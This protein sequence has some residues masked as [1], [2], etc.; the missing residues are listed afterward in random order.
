MHLYSDLSNRNITVAIC[1]R[2]M[3]SSPISIAPLQEKILPSTSIKL[4]STIWFVWSDDMGGEV[5]YVT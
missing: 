3:H 2:L 4:D 5:I 1:D